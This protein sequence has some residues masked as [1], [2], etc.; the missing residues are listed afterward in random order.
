[1]SL[2]KDKEIKELRAKVEEQQSLKE[3]LNTASEKIQQLETEKKD[4]FKVMLQEKKK[5][6]ELE[7]KIE[8][9]E[10]QASENTSK[11]QQVMKENEEL[12]QQI[13]SGMSA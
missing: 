13:D 5:N 1:M 11:L 6:A 4:I 2:V 12:H 8:D 9:Y 3:E 7:D 10:A